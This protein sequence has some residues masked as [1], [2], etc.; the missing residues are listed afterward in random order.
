MET[1]SCTTAATQPFYGPFSGTTQ[2]SLCQKRTF[3]ACSVAQAPAGAWKAYCSLSL[4]CHRLS[5]DAC[6]LP[7]VITLA[8][9]LAVKMAVPIDFK[10]QKG[11]YFH[12]PRRTRRADDE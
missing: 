8:A 1:E 3:E 12:C 9:F 6:R 2:V 4:A 10:T 5:A 7:K 11:Y